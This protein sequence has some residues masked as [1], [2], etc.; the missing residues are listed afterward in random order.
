MPISRRYLPLN[1]LRAF[2]VAG[3]HATLVNA[4]EELGV[5]HAA[6]SRQILLLEEQLSVPLFDRSGRKLKLT[7][8]GQHLLCESTRSF[9]QISAVIETLAPQSL[10]GPLNWA[11]TSSGSRSL[12]GIVGQFHDAYPD[13]EMHLTTLLPHA[14]EVPS[15]VD[16]S[17]CFGKPV[18]S[19]LH[20][21]ELYREEFFPVCAPQFLAEIDKQFDMR[22]ISKVT[23]IHDEH[24]RWPKWYQSQGL[25]LP[26]PKSDF[27]VRE[28]HMAIAAAIKGVG[29]AYADKLEINDELENGSLVK[30]HQG[31]LKC[32]NSYY[33][34]YKTYD[35][36]NIR[37]KTFID[38]LKGAFS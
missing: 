14:K 4:A 3:R 37:A 16:I 19:N 18:N 38:W 31:T 13:I 27:Y 10:N 23:L 15:N 34:V 36:L 22:D 29:I 30:L 1:A 11:T 7:S 5:T 33:L 20:V 6:L 17:I 12:M 28:A 21:E 26:K 32:E 25:S 8:A 2:E 35:N 9:D 24:N